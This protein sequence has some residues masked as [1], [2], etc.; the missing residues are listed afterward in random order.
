MK[1]LDIH[2]RLFYVIKMH[3]LLIGYDT[4]FFNFKRKE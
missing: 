1:V 2:S 3:F 4:N